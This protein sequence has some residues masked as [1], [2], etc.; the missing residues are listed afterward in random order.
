MDAF[1]SSGRIR[2]LCYPRN[3][4]FKPDTGIP[5]ICHCTLPLLSD[6]P[7]ALFDLL[8]AEVPSWP[9]RSG[10]D[11][12]RSLFGFLAQH[13]GKRVAVERSGGSI[14]MMQILRDQFPEARFVHIHRNGPDCAVSMSRHLTFRTRALQMML[15]RLE[16]QPAGNEGIAEQFRTLVTH[17]VDIERLM[18]FPIPLTFFGNMWSF[19]IGEGLKVLADL[20]A[21]RWTSIRYETVLT[22]PATELTR[23]ADFIGVTATPEWL[24]TATALIS[25]PGPVNISAELPPEVLAA[26]ERECAPGAEAVAA[27]EA[28]LLEGTRKL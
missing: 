24:T 1:F 20:P 10:A 11:Q 22:D 27:V 2:E 16:G 23:L 17:P 5:P 12:F 9:M 25:R 8:A 14:V 3:G 4:R 15:R 19:M 13:L 21:D 18:S 7:D 26:V 28:L 6:D